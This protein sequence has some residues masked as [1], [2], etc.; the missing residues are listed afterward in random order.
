MPSE[1]LTTSETAKLLG[2]SPERIR[3]L[4]RCGKLAARQTSTGQR[5][6]MLGDVERLRLER[7]ARD[8]QMG[9][10]KLGGKSHA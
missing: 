5:I 7:V 3:Q 1:I 6:F 8:H 4:H 10:H 2:L 9:N